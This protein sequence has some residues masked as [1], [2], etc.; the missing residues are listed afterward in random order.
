[1]DK[2]LF[3]KYNI[4]E[5]SEVKK[6]QYSDFMQFDSRARVRKTDVGFLAG[7]APV[8]KVG[9]MSYRQADGT[10]LRQF[11]PPETLFNKDSMD[12]LKMKPMTDTHPPERKVSVSNASFRQIGFTGETVVQ[13]DTRLEVS[14]TIT[15]A[16]AIAEIEKGRQEFSP[17][18]EVEVAFR[19][20]QFNG[21]NY[22]AVQV[23][24]RYNHLAVV[25]GARGGSDLRL[26]MDGAETAIFD[27]KTKN[28][29]QEQGVKYKIDGIEYDAAPEVVNLLSKVQTDLKTANDALKTANDASQALKGE[30]DTLKTQKDALEARDITGEVKGAVARRMELERMAGL[31]LDNVDSKLSDRALK[32]EAI[33][34]KLP[35]MAKKIDDKTTDAYI[36]A[37]L[38]T[39]VAGLDTDTLAAQRRTVGSQVA[40][41]ASLPDEAKA[42]K[43]M[44]ARE[45]K[46]WEPKTTK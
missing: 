4:D 7:T 40:N 3:K 45:Q 38:D 46:A 25:D 9:I 18:Y 32:I 42:R 33:K 1:M 37:V 21:E 5:A 31:V 26:Q 27:M 43:D 30:R 29:N 10:V 41:D 44:I 17:G 34:V 35:D 14:M 24:R 28:L 8:A 6:F 22:D 2:E 13:A 11:V 36:D 19:P 15:D 16:E 23:S 39:V 12:S 20:G